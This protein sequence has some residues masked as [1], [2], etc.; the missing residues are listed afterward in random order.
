M[1]A[2]PIGIFDSGMGGLTVAQEISKIL[3]NESMVYVGDT[4]YAPYGQRTPL[5]VAQRSN[6]IVEFLLTQGAKAVVIAC[7]T[8]TAL[9]L[10]PLT[11]QFTNVPI[12]DV[13]NPC[14]QRLATQYTGRLGLIATT[15][16]INGGMF[17]QLLGN[18]LVAAQAC[19]LFAPMAEAGLN[20]THPAVN[21]AAGVYLTPL[22]GKLDSLIL[23]CTHYPLFASAIK[24]AIGDIKLIN[25]GSFT[26]AALKQTLESNGL[27]NTGTANLHRF[28]VTGSTQAFCAAGGKIYKEVLDTCKITL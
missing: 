21:F 18:R 10:A 28:Y 24:T 12:V 17:G 5:E 13:I 1:D 6:I 11:A 19:P 22:R 16:T 14:V 2:R 26:A 9:A 7:G 8:A 23:G 25:M 20:S 4:A 27:T 3:P 15:A